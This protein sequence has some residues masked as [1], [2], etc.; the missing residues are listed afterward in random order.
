MP[1]RISEVRYFGSPPR[2]QRLLGLQWCGQGLTGDAD[3]T[4][5][6][7]LLD[8]A[9]PLGHYGWQRTGIGWCQPQ[10]QQ[11]ALPL[12]LGMVLISCDRLAMSGPYHADAPSIGTNTSVESSSGN[13]ALRRTSARDD[14]VILSTRERR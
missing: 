5:C 9:K 10:S 7:A 1:A 11:V 3:P 13:L 14:T 6:G 2:R 12:R 8:R 4:A